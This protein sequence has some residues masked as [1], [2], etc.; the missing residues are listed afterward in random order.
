MGPGS[1]SRVWEGPVAKYG[2]NSRRTVCAQGIRCPRY[3]TS[4]VAKNNW[5]ASERLPRRGRKLSERLQRA[6][7][8][9][10]MA[11]GTQ[12]GHAGKYR[13]RG[14]KCS[15]ITVAATRAFGREGRVQEIQ[16]RMKA[17]QCG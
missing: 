2:L 11:N 10:N 8:Y 9:A 7:M 16:T 17:A 14:Q 4:A 15:D 12:Q 1:A 3:T 5:K 6:R 13:S